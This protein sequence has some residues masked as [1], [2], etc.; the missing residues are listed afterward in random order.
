MISLFGGAA[1]CILPSGWVDASRF[2]QVPDHQEVYLDTVSSSSVIIEILES[3]EKGIRFC[4]D[5]LAAADSAVSSIVHKQETLPTIF[6]F[7]PNVPVTKQY[8]EG[9]Q[10]KGDCTKT[11][12]PVF[13]AMTLLRIPE[14]DILVTTHNVSPKVHFEICS[15][16]EFFNRQLFSYSISNFIEHSIDVNLATGFRYIRL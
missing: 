13:V 5:D 2:R 8:I 6:W 16:L 3:Q 1:Q 9:V 12:S 11:V 15:S 4:F 10:E 14:A 7:I